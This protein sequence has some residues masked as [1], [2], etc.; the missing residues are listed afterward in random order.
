MDTSNRSFLLDTMTLL[1]LSQSEL[2]APLIRQQCVVLEEI[3]HE[4][5]FAP[6]AE[7]VSQLQIE[8]DAAL[9][10]KV[11]ELLSQPV[12]QQLLNL[13]DYK[14]NGDVVLL[15]KALLERERGELQ[16]LPSEWVLVTDDRS[17][18]RAAVANQVAVCSSSEFQ[19][20]LTPPELE[21]AAS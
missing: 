14:G 21:T 19:K 1:R 13:Y 6:A 3:A 16:L 7:E 2:R 12:V 11:G 20:L 18:T 8:V 15:A 10:R 5:R 17:L 4:F 9:L